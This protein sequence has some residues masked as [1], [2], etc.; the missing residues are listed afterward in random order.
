MEQLEPR[1]GWHL[2]PEAELEATQAEPLKAKQDEQLE[3]QLEE[4]SVIGRDMQRLVKGLDPEPA[5]A[6]G[7]REQGPHGPHDFLL[8]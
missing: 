2:Q 7:E 3:L 8:Q 1:P 6:Q 5:Q 4:R